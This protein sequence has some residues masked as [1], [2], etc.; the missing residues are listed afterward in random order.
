MAASLHSKCIWKDLVKSLAFG[1]INM[2]L[3]EPHAW[4]GAGCNFNFK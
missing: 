4:C 2:L 3:K 1:K